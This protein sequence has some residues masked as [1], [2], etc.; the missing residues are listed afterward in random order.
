M[1]QTITLKPC[2]DCR[3]WNDCPG[4]KTWFSMSEI[5]Y[6]KFQVIWLISNLIDYQDGYIVVSDWP[7]EDIETG[8]DDTPVQH[9]NKAAAPFETLRRITADVTSRLQRTGKDG[10]LLLLE[11]KNDRLEF[12]EEANQAL[13]YISGWR[14]KRMN[15]GL[16]KKQR[17]Q[18]FE[19]R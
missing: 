19:R 18:R 9:S 17:R 11:I 6:C 3:N 13:S 14:T 12:S 15:Y 8:Y 16:W 5:R 7:Q 1:A 10:R 4:T 2:K